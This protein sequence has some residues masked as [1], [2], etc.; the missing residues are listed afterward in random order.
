MFGGPPLCGAP[1]PFQGAPSAAGYGHKRPGASSAGRAAKQPRHA[2]WGAAGAAH[3]AGGGDGALEGGDGSFSWLADLDT[4]AEAAAEMAS[5][6]PLPSAAWRPTP[7]PTAPVM[8]GRRPPLRRMPT[9]EEQALV[10]EVSRIRSTSSADFRRVLDLQREE[11]GDPQAIQS[12]YRQLMRLLHPDKRGAEAEERAGGREACDEAISKLQDALESAKQAAT[13]GPDPQQEAHDSM[14][15]LQELQRQRA[16]EAAMAASRKRE[17]EQ[18]S[19]LMMDLEAA[20]AASAPPPPSDWEGQG[21]QGE[22]D[23]DAPPSD[24]RLFRFAE[25]EPAQAPQPPTDDTA[26]QI[27][28]L[29]AQMTGA[30]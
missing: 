18:V 22:E 3:Q 21:W 9:S 16:Q 29:L 28:R 24:P 17:Q 7:Q 12:R 14:R 26:N 15:R 1:P 23:D 2:A 4:W 20:L 19:N 5:G 25:P 8:P 30:P 13:A 27:A 10:D 6:T 11:Y